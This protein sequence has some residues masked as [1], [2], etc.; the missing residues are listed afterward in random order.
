[1]MEAGMEAESPV[2]TEFAP[3]EPTVLCC[4]DCVAFASCIAAALPAPR[5]AR[6]NPPFCFRRRLAEGAPLYRAG[7]P[8]SA[9][10]VIRCGSFK[11][12]II[13]EDGREQITGIHLPGTVVGIE[14]IAS[15]RHTRNVVAMEESELCVLSI[16][17]LDRL[18]AELPGVQRW[19]HRALSREIVAATDELTLLGRRKAEDRLEAFL[20]ALAQR[21]MALGRSP[22]DFDLRLTRQ[23]IASHLG[24]NTATV[25]RA[26]TQLSRKGVITVA[27]Q[28]VNL[29]RMPVPVNEEGTP[30]SH[31][32]AEVWEGH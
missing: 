16:A 2:P 15:G 29:L 21:F 12:Q 14:G 23:E 1:M 30:K 3:G 7:E 8:L 27:K 9:V 32:S 6:L 22:H 25:S 24:L 26:F 19:F 28:R 18:A 20:L 11:S 10:Y 31:L 13:S 5:R 17:D 4:G